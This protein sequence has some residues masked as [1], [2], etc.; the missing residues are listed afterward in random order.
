MYSEISSDWN[1]CLYFFSA[2]NEKVEFAS[3]WPKRKISVKI[4]KID[5]FEETFELNS[6]KN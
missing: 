2:W 4:N 5:S 6:R 3:S 1:D